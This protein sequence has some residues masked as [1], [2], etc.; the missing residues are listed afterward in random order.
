MPQ[1]YI[2]LK[3]HRDTISELKEKL[4]TKTQD[5]IDACQTI[6]DLKLENKRADELYDQAMKRTDTLLEQCNE[7]QCKIN[8][9]ENDKQYLTA[10]ATEWKT[11]ATKYLDK[12]VSLNTEAKLN[13]ESSKS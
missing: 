8:L 6:A 3:Q 9:L 5:W 2:N 11:V 10:L 1:G 12:L 4:E 13:D 7:K